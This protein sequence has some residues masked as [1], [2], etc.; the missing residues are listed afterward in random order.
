[1]ISKMIKFGIMGVLALT[2]AAC[3]DAG[4]NDGHHESAHQETTRSGHDAEAKDNHGT[5]HQD[6]HSDHVESE[7]VRQAGS[8]VHGDAM[9]AMALDGTTLVIELESPLHNLLGF[10]HAPQTVA[11]KARL[12]SVEVLLAAPDK[13][14]AFSDAARCQA[15]QPIKS[16]SLLD[17]D[18]D[19]HAEDEH[20]SDHKDTLVEYVYTCNSP[21]KLTKMT[22]NLF[23]LFPEMTELDTVFLGPSAQIQSTLKPGNTTLSLTK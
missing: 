11:Q 1:M 22:T 4:H 6:T 13:L 8:H 20:E 19:H 16:L 10:E 21:D 17:H 3:G 18:E 15:D 2:L 23:E 14:F 5:D 9:L 12:Q 7:A